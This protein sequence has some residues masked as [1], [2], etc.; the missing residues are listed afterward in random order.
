MRRAL[1]YAAGAVAIVAAG[2]VVAAR[3]SPRP[4]AAA[5]RAVFER[6][7]RERHR[8]LEVGR[9]GDVDVRTFAY[10]DG[11]LLDVYSPSGAQTPLPCV[12]WTHGGAGLS[13]SRTDDAGWFARLAREGFVVVAAD[14]RLAPGAV[15]PSAL[16]DVTDALAVVLARAADL[17]VDPARVVLG[18]DSAGAQMTAQL[19]AAIASP[20][21]RER[22]GLRDVLDPTALRGAVLACGYYDLDVFRGAEAPLPAPLGWAVRTILWAVTGERE[23]A[24]DLLDEMSTARHVT[25]SFPPALLIGGDDDPLTDTQS[26]PLAARLAGLGVDVTTVFYDDEPLPGLPHEF[27]FDLSTSQARAAFDTVVAFLI[28]VTA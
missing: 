7:G 2:A 12:V 8:A 3:V 28:R 10:R 6:G 22:I 14:D 18:G 20:A 23:P 26:R 15:Y 13:G 19:A 9:P 1:G 11:L 5:I 24:P 16:H 4:G 27:Q 21:Y 25:A 17:G